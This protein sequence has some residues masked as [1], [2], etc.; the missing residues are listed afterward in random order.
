MLENVHLEVAVDVLGLADALDVLYALA[1]ARKRERRRRTPGVRETGG[2]TDGRLRGAAEQYRD[3][4]GG[5][6]RHVRV[7]A[8]V[9]E[10][11]VVLQRPGGPRCT[12]QADG[13]GQSL[14]ALVGRDAEGLELPRVGADSKAER[15]P[16]ARQLVDRR[17]VFRQPDRVVQRR[18]RD[19]GPDLDVVGDG[20]QRAQGGEIGRASCRERVSSPV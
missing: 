17:G 3:V 18:Q 13:I 1:D 20:G 16:A 9:V 19:A 4:V 11:G 7:R 14:D 12:E 8:D 5:F 6:W 2:A 15:R 10:L